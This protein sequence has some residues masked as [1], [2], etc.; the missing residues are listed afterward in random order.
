[1]AQWR[2]PRPKSGGKKEVKCVSWR[3]REQWSTWQKNKYNLVHR[4]W[5]R[6]FG[7]ILDF[8]ISKGRR[9]LMPATHF[10]RF[11]PLLAYLFV[12]AVKQSENNVLLIWF[13]SFLTNVT[14]APSPHSLTSSLDHCFPLVFLKWVGKLSAKPN[15]T[16][17]VIKRR[18]MSSPLPS[19]VFVLPHCRVTALIR[20]WLATVVWHIAL[21]QKLY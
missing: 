1:M 3:G 9:S 13:T 19:N 6:S 16:F 15:F 10:C 14:S 11:V 2:R 5:R 12:S 4:L 7:H 8:L 21:L 20:L 17:N 18:E